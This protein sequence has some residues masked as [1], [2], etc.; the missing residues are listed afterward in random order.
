METRLK[1]CSKCKTPKPESE[2][3][4]RADGERRR[5]RSDC[6][7]CFNARTMAKYFRDKTVHRRASRKFLLKRY[8]I[9]VAVYEAMLR[10]QHGLCALCCGL[11]Q[12]NES[13]AV[14]HDHNTGRVRGLL[15]RSCNAGLGQFGDKVPM[16]HRAIAYLENRGD[17]G[18][19]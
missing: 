4:R 15:C 12:G 16:L 10:H 14:D 3:Y 13:L 7:V 9:S 6:K 5:L 2:F 18:P 17:F 8:G 19:T 1:E 11:R